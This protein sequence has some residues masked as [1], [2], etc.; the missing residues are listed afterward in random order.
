MDEHRIGLKPIRA[1]RVGADWAPSCGDGAASLRLALRGRLCPSRLGPHHLSSGHQCLRFPSLKRSWRLL[2]E[3]SALVGGSRLSS[4]STGPAGIPVSVCRCHRLVHLLFLPPYSPELQP[5]EHLWSLT[6]TVLI[7]QHFATMDELE[8]VQ[9]ARCAT[10][11][12]QPALI[13]STTCFHW[14]PR[15]I[16]QRRGPRRT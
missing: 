15:Q 5:A 1:A 6:N 10:L 3:L 7:N 16:H 12:Q 9:L 2:P 14:W 13:R 4:C 8:E 11:Q